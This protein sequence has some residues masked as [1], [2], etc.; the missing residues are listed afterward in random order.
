MALG[1]CRSG[2]YPSVAETM[3]PAGTEFGEGEP[4]LGGPVPAIAPET[5][6]GVSL[7]EGAHRAVAKDLGHNTRG[8]DRRAPGIGPGKA[9]HLGTEIQVAI[10][11]AA[12]GA[13]LQGS[14]SPHQGFAIRLADAVT[15]DPPGWVGYY[16]DGLGPAEQ[17]AEDLFAQ[18]G[19]QQFGVVDPGDLSVAED[20]GRGHQRSCQRATSGLI[21]PGKRPATTQYPCRVESAERT[22]LRRKAGRASP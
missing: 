9:L 5:V 11:K 12:P 8:G 20:Y 16:G 1:L 10:R 18:R 19:P 13:R 7:G 2:S 21:S 4:V 3:D 15:V 14:E 22:L 17:R 6:T